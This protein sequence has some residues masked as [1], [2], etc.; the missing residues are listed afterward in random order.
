MEKNIVL[1]GFMGTGKTA[2]GTRLASNLN[3]EF[4]DTD[5]E[6]ERITGMTIR[7]IFVKYGEVR[8]R[9]EE[10]LLSQKLARRENLVIAT[11]GGMVL[12]P[13]NLKALRENGIMVRLKATPEEIYKR[14][15]RKRQ[16]RPLLGK[17]FTVEDIARMLEEREP[18]YSQ[19]D[20]EVDTGDKDP[21]QIVQIIIDYLKEREHEESKS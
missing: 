6:I 19:A 5:R 18:Y 21:D 15:K 9:S 20:L 12:N 4:I 10:A 11:G 13:D 1:I 2:I 8:F 16:N 17:N 3:R 14:V 7:D